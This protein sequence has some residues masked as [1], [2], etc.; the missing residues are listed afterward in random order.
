MCAH[1]KSR[2][3]ETGVICTLSFS[4]DSSTDS[5]NDPKTERSATDLDLSCEDALRQAILDQSHDGTTQGTGTVGW[6]E[7]LGDQPVTYT[8]NTSK[9]EHCIWLKMSTD[10]VRHKALCRVGTRALQAR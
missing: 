3:K 5:S 4:L 1:T 9:C 10:D 8:R 6:V 2:S 7:A